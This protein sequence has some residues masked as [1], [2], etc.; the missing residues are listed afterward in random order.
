MLQRTP[1]LPDFYFL[2]CFIGGLNHVVKPFVRALRP[3]TVVE[4]IQLGKCQ[5]EAINATFMDLNLKW[6]T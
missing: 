1:L 3:P 2:D 5:E 6:T 4:A